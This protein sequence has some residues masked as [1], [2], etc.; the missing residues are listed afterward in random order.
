MTCGVP[1]AVIKYYRV[2]LKFKIYGDVKLFPIC[3]CAHHMYD[4]QYLEDFLAISA[5]SELPT[6]R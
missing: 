4:L 3:L 5:G 6:I 2:S 1:H